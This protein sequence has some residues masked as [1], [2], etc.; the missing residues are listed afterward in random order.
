MQFNN[1][2]LTLPSG[3]TSEARWQ[4]RASDFEQRAI[5]AEKRLESVELL[6]LFV[7]DIVDLWPTITVRTLWKMTDKVSSLKECLKQIK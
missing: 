5:N 4:K 2:Q 7:K 3:T 1:D 6:L